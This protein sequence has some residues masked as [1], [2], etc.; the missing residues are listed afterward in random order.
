MATTHQRKVL[1][2]VWPF[3]VSNGKPVKPVLA[4]P[5]PKREQVPKHQMPPGEE[6]LL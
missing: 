1:R 2:H 3:P 4:A 5:L 6:A